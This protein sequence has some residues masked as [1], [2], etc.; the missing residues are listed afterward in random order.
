MLLP[1]LTYYLTDNILFSVASM[2]Q[3]SCDPK[4]AQKPYH[5]QDVDFEDL[6]GCAADRY[7]RLSAMYCVNG[8]SKTCHQLER[9]IYASLE[10][11]AAPHAHSLS[12]CWPTTWCGNIALHVT[13]DKTGVS[14]LCYRRYRSTCRSVLAADQLAA[15][16]ESGGGRLRCH[17][18]TAMRCTPVARGRITLMR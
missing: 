4:S 8:P 1:T 5:A 3:A 17:A 6:A 11:E 14:W 2:V 9:T 10:V 7:F 15:R 18:G 16:N 12:L 13:W